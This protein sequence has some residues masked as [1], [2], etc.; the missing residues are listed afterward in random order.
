MNAKRFFLT[1]LSL[2]LILATL[3]PL[4]SC[5]VTETAATE[6]VTTAEPA[7]AG[8]TNPESMAAETT[9]EPAKYT[10]VLNAPASTAIHTAMQAQYLAES[11]PD[12]ASSYAAGQEELGRP[13]PI[14]LTWDVE[15]ELA[16][17]CIVRATEDDIYHIVFNLVENAIKYNL[18]MGKVRVTV[19]R[20]GDRCRL[21][22]E[23]TGIGIPEAD[24]PN[25]FTRFYRVDKAR[26]REHGGSG[27]GLSIVHDAVK[28]YGGEII[29]EGVEPHGTRFIVDF[30]AA[31]D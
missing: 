3:F 23:D 18:P 12:T 24:R 5:G 26:S 19:R 14:I 4:A 1:A 30:P 20:E 6:A 2:L 29:L 8:I 13:N 21:V 9:A 11:D 17:G 7:T 15:T 31:E 28:L 27:L 22:V 16:E 10:V 25:V